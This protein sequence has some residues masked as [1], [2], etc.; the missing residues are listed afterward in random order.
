MLRTKGRKFVDEKGREIVLKSIGIGGWLMMEGYMLGG[1]NIPE[2]IFKATL[3]KI[4]G[5][6]KADRFA[7]QFCEHFFNEKDVKRIKK[8]GF[9]CARLPI[10]Y[11]VLM[12]KNGFKL[13]DKVVGWFR[14]YQVYLILDL[15]AAPGSQNYDW[16]SDSDG[17]AHL[18]DSDKY[19]RQTIAL[20][21]VI[22]KRYRDENIIAG[23]DILNE[24]VT[25]KV[26]KVNELYS[27]IIDVIRKNSDDHIIFVEPNM[28]AFDLKGMKVPHDDNFAWSVH[29]YV[30]HDFTFNL[31]PMLKSPGRKCL[32]RA[33]AVFLKVQKRDNVPVF[34]GEFGVAARCPVCNSE[35]KWVRDVL[36]IFREFG[37]SW[38]Y[39]TYKSVAGALVPDGLY[40]LYDREMF[41]R[42]TSEP[43]MENIYKVLRYAESRFYGMLDTKNFQLH[44]KLLD[45][46]I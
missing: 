39:W 25:K 46:L 35:L 18:W 17:I 20:W 28:W 9:N 4:Y 40:R 23:Y 42:E 1:K 16:H 21:A 24:P 2:H 33:L 26:N 38:S 41:G 6:A 11:R 27:K 30:P 19:F 13:L 31:N 5:K 10:N 45:T 22:S 12:E 43:G 37:W 36:S 32:K 3:R 44:R 8:L 34:V 29:F 14:K 7:G 15:H